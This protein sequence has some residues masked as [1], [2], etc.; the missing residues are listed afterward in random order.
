M[1]TKRELINQLEALDIDDDALVITKTNFGESLCENITNVR[2]IKTKINVGNGG[3]QGK[4]ATELNVG[5]ESIKKPEIKC[6][7]I[8]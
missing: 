2:T 8:N 5:F 3:T 6:V 7:Y 1:L 4:H